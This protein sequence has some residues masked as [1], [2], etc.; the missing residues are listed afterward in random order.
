M[1][2]PK[3]FKSGWEKID[4]PNWL[5][6]YIYGLNDTIRLGMLYRS[7]VMREPGYTSLVYNCQSCSFVFS[8]T[9]INE[10]IAGCQSCGSPHLVS[11][12]KRPSPKPYEGK[13]KDLINHLLNQLINLRSLY[14]G[15]IPNIEIRDFGFTKTGCYFQITGG[16]SIR[17]EGTSLKNAAFKAALMCPFLWDF[18]FNWEKVGVRNVKLHNILSILN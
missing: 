12:V 10:E 17:A 11:C 1:Q 16:D 13:T 3:L 2:K 14:T 8:S 7:L 6:E 9:K 4:A 18:D 15:K 5:P